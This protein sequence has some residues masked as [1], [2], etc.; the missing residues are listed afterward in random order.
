MSPLF[1]HRDADGRERASF[2]RHISFFYWTIV[3]D[4]NVDTGVEFSGLDDEVL[5]A[6]GDTPAADKPLVWLS[7]LLLFVLLLLLVVRLNGANAWLL[8]SIDLE[9]TDN[10]CTDSSARW[11]DSRNAYSGRTGKCGGNVLLKLR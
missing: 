4:G 7:L 6:D 5:D 3:P 11:Y 2:G 9:M 1:L 10:G 8:F